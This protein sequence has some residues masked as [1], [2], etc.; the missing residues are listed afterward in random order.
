ML[1][2]YNK[3]V[4]FKYRNKKNNCHTI[5]SNWKSNIFIPQSKYVLFILDCVNPKY[6]CLFLFIKFYTI[7]VADKSIETNSIN[8]L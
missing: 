8:F 2:F 3:S 4:Q 6:V 1:K 5:N 7:S